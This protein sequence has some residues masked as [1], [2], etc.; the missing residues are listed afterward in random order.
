MVVKTVSLLL[1]FVALLVSNTFFLLVILVVALGL[2]IARKF[3][4]SMFLNRVLL[5][6][7]FLIAI[8]IFNVKMFLMIALRGVIAITLLAVITDGLSISSLKQIFRALK[9]PDYFSEIFALAFRYSFSLTEEIL[10]LKRCFYLRGG[11]HRKNL[12]HSSILG[13]IVGHFFVRTYYKSKRIYF[14]MK[15]RGF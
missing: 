13:P 9:F 10:L 6:F 7:P 14:I 11:F 4:V 3:S 2:L 15:L 12:L 1:L 5:L 8:S